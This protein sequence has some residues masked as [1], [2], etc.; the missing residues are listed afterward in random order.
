LDVFLDEVGLV[1]EMGSEGDA[2]GAEPLAG[3]DD[4]AGF[5]MPAEKTVA[6]LLDVLG[7]PV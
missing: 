4:D 2:A 5:V 3:D 6:E 7:T 1:P